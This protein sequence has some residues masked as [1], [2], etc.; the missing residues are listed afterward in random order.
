MLV[1]DFESTA[2]VTKGYHTTAHPDVVV[3]G[4]VS[5]CDMAGQ[6]RN[7][8]NNHIS[9]CH[10]KKWKTCRGEYDRIRKR[11]TRR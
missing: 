10:Y 9:Y 6:V 2:D 8:L 11:L 1:S 7:S 5:V 4:V 3:V